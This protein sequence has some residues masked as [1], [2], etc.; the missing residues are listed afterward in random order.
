LSKILLLEDDLLL[1]ETLIDL[2]E[3]NGMEVIHAPNGQ[4]ALDKTFK[5]KFDLYL[6]DV[7]VPL[8]D[9]VTLLKELRDSSDETPAIFLTSHKEKEMLKKGF[10]CGADDFIT[11]PFDTDELILRI[12]ALLKRAKKEDVTCIG[13][14]CNDDTH[15]RFLYDNQEIELSKKEYQLLLLLMRHANSTVPKEMIL[16]TLWTSS[17]GGS[18]GALRVYV[19]RI[20][21]LVPEINIEN[22][23]GIGYRLVS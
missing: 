20:K 15:K 23:R 13:L 6:L 14:L 11:K 19:N 5:Q 1:A 10:L 9:G 16:D 8:I 3:E 7:N 18:D 12:S 2:L 22:I 17:E 21:H 4:A